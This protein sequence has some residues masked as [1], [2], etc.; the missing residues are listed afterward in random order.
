MFSRKTDCF[1]NNENSTCSLI[2]SNSRTD[3]IV[4]TKNN[5]SLKLKRLDIV[6]DGQKS[7]LS[8]GM[9]IQKESHIDTFLS[10]N[11]I[12]S[13]NRLEFEKLTY[14]K[15]DPLSISSISK[16]MKRLCS[17]L[18]ALFDFKH[19]ELI[20]FTE[21]QYRWHWFNI[22]KCTSIEEFSP[23]QVIFAPFETNDFSLKA[24]KKV[25][26]DLNAFYKFKPHDKEKKVLR[27]ISKGGRCKKKRDVVAPIKLDQ[28]STNNADNM[29]QLEFKKAKDEIYDYSSKQLYKPG[30]KSS[31]K[32]SAA[33][34]LQMCL[35]STISDVDKTQC[36]IVKENSA[37]ELT[38]TSLDRHKLND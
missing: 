34:I 29:K 36:I 27:S 7:E 19:S 18:N 1:I 17:I 15:P 26:C 12:Y 8:F 9:D 33:R 13:K 35:A 4:C 21:E 3:Q 37:N 38:N 25:I 24:T 23:Y 16:E 10:I 6:D 5:D 28:T 30:R 2:N 20:E 14:F 32:E 22:L 11:E 31:S